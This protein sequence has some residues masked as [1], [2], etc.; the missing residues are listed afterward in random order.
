MGE[1]VA[2]EREPPAIEGVDPSSPLP[3]LPHEA[4]PLQHVQVPGRRRPCVREHRG[5]VA[6]G[7]RAA[8][9]VQR[10]HDAPADGMRQGGEQRFVRV[11]SCHAL[12][13]HTAKCSVNP[14]TSR[15]G[16]RQAR[17]VDLFGTIDYDPKYDYKKQRRRR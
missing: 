12:F 16:R 13:S 2:C 10:H 1:P 8:L 11:A 3:R 5:D 9:E 15:C 14:H 7:H 4:R 6:G 17:I